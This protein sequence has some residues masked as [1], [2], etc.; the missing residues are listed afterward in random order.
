MTRVLIVQET[1]WLKRGPHQQHHLFERLAA[2]GLP[3]TALD[4]EI[5][6]T[7]WPRAPLY[8][9]RSRWDAVT[10][11]PNPSPGVTLIRPA[12]LRLPLLARPISLFTFYAELVRQ[13]QQ[14]RPDVIVNYALSTGLPALMAARRFKI[15]FL[16]HVIEALHTIVP[17]ALLQPIARLFECGL[18][19]AADH[20]LYINEELRDYGIG[21]GAD[22][23]RAHMI[24]TGVD[25]SRFRPDLDTHA[26]RAQW[27]IAESDVV[28]LFIGWLYE[29]AGVDVLMRQL[30]ALPPHVRLLVVGVGDM[31]QKLK[32]LHA[33]LGLGNR[34]IFTGQQPY[35]LA[36]QFMALADVC[37]LYSTINNITRH[38]VPIKTYEYMAAGRPVLASPLPGVMR[39]V[40]PGNGVLY[41]PETDLASALQSLLDPTYRH[42][43]GTQARTFVETHCDWNHLTDQFQTLLQ[44]ISTANLQSPI[45]SL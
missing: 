9:P 8:A 39:D 10:R 11:T 36:P 32:A 5:L 35:D 22:P 30:A 25:L 27:G 43:L 41:I 29:H 31:E 15:P 24:R 34:V 12:T 23:K 2:R 1:D 7:P 33:E 6:Y 37:T 20:T 21:L 14:N 45:S 17:S 42:A 28:L 3:I 40:P 13:C 18:L 26:L 44:T 19:R 16:F 38:I 4:F